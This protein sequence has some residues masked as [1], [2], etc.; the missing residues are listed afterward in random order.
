MY[1]VR[2]KAPKDIDKHEQFQG[3]EYLCET[4]HQRDTML[5]LFKHWITEVKETPFLSFPNKNQQEDITYQ[6]K[7]QN[8]GIYACLNENYRRN[9]MEENKEFEMWLD[10]TLKD[11]EY[12]DM[13]EL[14][15]EQ[16]ELEEL[17]Q[18][19]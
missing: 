19:A 4:E 6:I 2:V 14:D 16:K 3:C 12:E 8:K 17:F 13:K 9:N 18:H 7:M 5:E 11:M 1:I 15:K 10:D